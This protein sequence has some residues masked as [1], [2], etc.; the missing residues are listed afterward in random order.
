M[1]IIVTWR[2]FDFHAQIDGRPG[3]WGCGSS[4]NEAIGDLVRSHPEVLGVEVVGPPAPA[5][6]RMSTRHDDGTACRS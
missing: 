3:L 4:A 6:A 2:L 1:K 5:W